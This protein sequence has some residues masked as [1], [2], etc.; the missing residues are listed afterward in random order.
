MKKNNKMLLCIAVIC[1]MIC[2]AL[3]VVLVI[4]F[5]K[6]VSKKERYH[7][8]LLGAFPYEEGVWFQEYDYGYQQKPERL[9]G[10]RCKYVFYGKIVGSELFHTNEKSNP[11]SNTLLAY[12]LLKVK[13]LKNIY[14]EL[15][16]GQETYM[17]MP[18][19][20]Y[21]AEEYGE[22]IQEGGEGLFNPRAPTVEIEYH[23]S[24]KKVKAIGMVGE[25]DNRFCCQEELLPELKKLD[26][27][28][29][30]QE[31]WEENELCTMGGATE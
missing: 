18:Y 26:S 3:V 31:F 25:I 23:G 29:E 11:E 8:M 16:K 20:G 10:E 9:F 24:D 19:S 21:T 14:G 2:V 7:V 6:P 13:V 17:V 22:C 5:V 4:H 12:A 1:G 28:E 27:L 30:V 15:K